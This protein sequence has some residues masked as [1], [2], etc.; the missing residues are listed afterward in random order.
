MIYG[1]LHI[2]LQMK[3]GFRKSTRTRLCGVGRCV[4]RRNLDSQSE[5][6]GIQ[7]KME[8]GKIPCIGYTRS[9]SW[10]VALGEIAHARALPRS[11]GAMGCVKVGQGSPYWKF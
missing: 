8:G 9:G 3:H 1:Q 4:G 2:Q 11:G 10:W 7:R 6:L 5:I